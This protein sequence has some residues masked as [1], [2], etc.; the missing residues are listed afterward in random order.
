MKYFTI[1]LIVLSLLISIC[2]LLFQG[3]RV[4]KKY[5]L[6]NRADNYIIGKSEDQIM[7][8]H[9]H[10][11]KISIPF[12]IIIIRSNIN[13][14]MEHYTKECDENLIIITEVTGNGGCLFLWIH[15]LGHYWISVSYWSELPKMLNPEYSLAYWKL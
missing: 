5:R 8:I 7:M 1:E 9:L 15:T 6:K 12:I 11:I 14:N 10:E 13:Q 4:V 3:N 2:C